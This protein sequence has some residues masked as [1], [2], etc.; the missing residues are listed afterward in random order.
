[1]MMTAGHLTPGFQKIINTGYASI[2]KQAQ[3][4]MG[5]HKN[6]LMGEDLNKY[7]FYTAATIVCDAV[8]ILIQRYGR[9]CFEKAQ[10]CKDSSRKSELLKMA[11][12]LMWIS[13][14]PA[15]TF[16]EACQAA[17]LYQLFLALETG[18]PGASF[19]RFD[20]YTWPFLKADLDIKRLV[21]STLG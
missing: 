17:M 14:N 1:M 11:D 2:R 7:I 9:A 19:G 12:G 4:W 15:R 20:Q 5:A 13:Q 3:D 10:A 18:Y 6:N 8:S 16:W 21:R